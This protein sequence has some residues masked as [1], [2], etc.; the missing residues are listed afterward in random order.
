MDVCNFTNFSLHLVWAAY[1]AELLNIPA[2]FSNAFFL[3]Y[4][5]K[6]H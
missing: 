4:H 1:S 6:F 2:V 3:S 5:A